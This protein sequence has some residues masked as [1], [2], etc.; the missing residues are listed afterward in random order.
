MDWNEY[1]I[2]LKQQ[3]KETDLNDDTRQKLEDLDDRDIL[4]EGHLKPGIKGYKRV[5]VDPEKEQNFKGIPGAFF[6]KEGD[7]VFIPI[8]S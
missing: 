3:A 5:K 4:K 2:L 1:A 8:K 7:T 6:N